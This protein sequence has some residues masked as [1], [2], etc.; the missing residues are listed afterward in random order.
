MR[1]GATGRLYERLTGEQLEMIHEASCRLLW[2][3]GVSVENEEAKQILLHHGG[4]LINEGNLAGRIKIPKRMVEEAIDKTP[5]VINLGARDKG[6]VLTLDGRKTEVFWVP[7]GEALKVGEIRKGET[8]YSL[9]LREPT[10]QDLIEFLIIAEKLNFDGFNRSVEANVPHE[11]KDE[12]KAFLFQKYFSGHTMLAELKDIASLPKVIHIAEIVA[13]G[14]NELEKNPLISFINCLTVSPLRLDRDTTEKFLRIGEKG[15]AIAISADSQAGLTASLDEIGQVIQ[16]NAEVLSAVV[17]GQFANP[18]TPLLYGAIP[19]MSDPH[20]AESRWGTLEVF[21]ALVDKSQM[22]RFYG[23]PCYGTAGVP[24]INPNNFTRSDIITS[25]VLSYT[26]ELASGA[27]Y[28]HDA[29]GL[30]NAGTI[31]N[32]ERYILDYYLIKQVEQDHQK[33]YEQIVPYLFKPEVTLEKIN[34]ELSEIHEAI[35][36]GRRLVMIFSKRGRKKRR[37]ASD[38][39]FDFSQYGISFEEA[40][41]IKEDLLSQPVKTFPKDTEE[42]ILNKFPKIKTFL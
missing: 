4:Q 23:I 11:N 14:K 21:T 27:Q 31:V 13:D 35:S 16:N 28:I 15:I 41:R 6:R 26:L 25:N 37:K 32:K 20:T 8:S 7:G 24:D 5:K 38:K 22:S 34:Q 12:V 29:F 10:T 36:G 3:T 2:E 42:Q 18:G 30:A 33:L 9:N 40:R 17:L 1:I 39:I 19:I